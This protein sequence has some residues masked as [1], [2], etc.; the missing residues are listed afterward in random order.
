MMG[1]EPR[2]SVPFRVAWSSW[3]GNF[4]V[5]LTFGRRPISTNTLFEKLFAPLRIPYRIAPA[6]NGFI[7]VIYKRFS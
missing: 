2:S 5:S 4:R 1:T 6:E 3:I 7:C